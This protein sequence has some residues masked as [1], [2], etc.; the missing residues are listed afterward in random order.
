MAEQYL[1]CPNCGANATNHQ[2]CEY[3]GSLLVR[4]VEKGIDLSRTSYLTNAKVF[5]GLI[6]NLKRNLKLQNTYYETVVTDIIAGYA[7]EVISISVLRTGFA[8]WHDHQKITLGSGNKGFIISIPFKQGVRGIEL[9]ENGFEVLN[10]HNERQNRFK[11]L[12]CY[13]LFTVYDSIVNGVIIREY[14]IDFGEDVEGAARLISEI[15]QKVFLVPEIDSL[16]LYTDYGEQRI[17]AMRQKANKD[18]GV[19]TTKPVKEVETT[20]DN[21]VSWWWLIGFGAFVLIALAKCA[22]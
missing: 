8:I 17:D 6:E 12:D 10:K 4:F 22:F 5:P 13:Q 7:N 20:D 14:A 9:S 15:L 2:N 19:N 1:R 3:C 21:D 16:G 11:S 18:F